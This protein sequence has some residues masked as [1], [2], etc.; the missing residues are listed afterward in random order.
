M[1]IVFRFCFCLCLSSE[2]YF[3]LG[4]GCLEIDLRYGSGKHI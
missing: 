2:T 1:M 3:G 4:I